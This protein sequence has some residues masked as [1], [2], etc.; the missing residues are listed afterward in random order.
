MK[1]GKALSEGC[2]SR[3]TSKPG[4][5]ETQAPGA[6]NASAGFL[7]AARGISL[8]AVPDPRIKRE[9]LGAAFLIDLPAIA[10]RS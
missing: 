2:H 10:R 6:Q 7:G 5:R 8:A 3:S 4:G 1:P 9:R